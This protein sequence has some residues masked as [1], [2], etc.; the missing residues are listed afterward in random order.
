[1]KCDQ[2]ASQDSRTR[3]V[4]QCLG[5]TPDDSNVSRR[6]CSL[7]IREFRIATPEIAC[8]TS[9]PVWNLEV[10]MCCKNTTEL[11]AVEAED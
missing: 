1:M 10:N 2:F 8:K 5:V 4:H 11:P 6:R 9:A 7:K 3:A